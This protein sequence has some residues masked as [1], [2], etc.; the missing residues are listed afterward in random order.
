MAVPDESLVGACLAEIQAV[1][2]ERNLLVPFLVV[3]DLVVAFLEVAM[4]GCDLAEGE[5]EVET[6]LH[7][8]PYCS[9]E[10]LPIVLE[11]EEVAEDARIA[12][13]EARKEDSNPTLI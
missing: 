6:E 8:L 5:E 12:G 11:V 2:E 1:P 4:V 10:G 7:I 3:A 13:A 9:E